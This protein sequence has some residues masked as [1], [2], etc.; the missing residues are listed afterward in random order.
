MSHSSSSSRKGI[1]GFNYLGENLAM[2]HGATGPGGVTMWYDEIKLTNGGRVTSFGS[3]TGHYTQ[4]VWKSSTA[5]GCG[6]YKSL[7]V[8]QYGNGGN[9]GGQ[10][11]SNVN[12]PVKSACQ[13]VGAYASAYDGYLQSY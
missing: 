4:V 9:M 6:V 13:S 1:G 10:F 5:L 12:G 7:L 2:G 8:C 11:A 3:G